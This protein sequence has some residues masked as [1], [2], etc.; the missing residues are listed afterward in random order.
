VPSAQVGWID[1]SGISKLSVVRAALVCIGGSCG[2]SCGSGLFSQWWQWRLVVAWA[3]C[4]GGGRGGGSKVNGGGRGSGHSNLGLPDGSGSFG[5]G[6][7]VGCK[8]T[9]NGGGGG[10]C[11]GGCYGAGKCCGHRAVM[12]VVWMTV[13]GRG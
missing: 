6:C 8:G 12:V 9:G 5:C 11:V 13:A 3:S 7:V 4:G 1:D 10:Y 2:H